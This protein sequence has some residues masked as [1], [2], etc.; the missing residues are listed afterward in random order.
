MNADSS[1]LKKLARTLPNA[2]TPFSDVITA[3][4]PSIDQLK[5]LG[6]AGVHMVLDLR[7][8]DEDRGFAEREVVEGAG[9]EYR[10]IPVSYDG[11]SDE[12]FDAVRVAI[13]AH[14]PILIH[15]RS[16][17]RVGGMMLP[18]LALDEGRDID[19][20]FDLACAIGL[21]NAALTEW[22][23]DYVERHKEGTT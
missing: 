16:A 4:Q 12:T 22:A 17:N 2:A 13:G 11:V 23:M 6:A 5:A 20:A 19:D 8:P 14:R 10:N 1:E 3:G 15:C 18:Y 9:M 7:L 21:K